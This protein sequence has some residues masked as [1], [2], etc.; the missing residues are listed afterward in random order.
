MY[1]RTYT[2][3]SLTAGKYRLGVYTNGNSVESWM[4]ITGSKVIYLAAGDE[5]AL[6][7]STPSSGPQALSTVQGDSSISIFYVAP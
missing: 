1:L 2:G 3:P 4:T 7:L 6:E 5:A